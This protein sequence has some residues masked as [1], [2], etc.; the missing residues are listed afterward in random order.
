MELPSRSGTR[1]TQQLLFESFQ[2]GQE[3]GDDIEAATA[4]ICSR[5]TAAGHIRRRDHAGHRSMD[6]A[7][8][9]RRRL[10]RDQRRIAALYH[11]ANRLCPW[12]ERSIHH[13]A[14]VGWGGLLR[15]CRC[16]DL[17]ILAR[18]GLMVGHRSTRSKPDG[19][20]RDGAWQHAKR[21]STPKRWMIE[22][23]SG[24]D[25]KRAALTTLHRHAGQQERNRHDAQ[26]GQYRHQVSDHV[27]SPGVYQQRQHNSPAGTKPAFGMTRAS[28]KLRGAT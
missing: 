13:R 17:G 16:G 20:A 7:A 1:S 11:F 23:V 8:H 19:A 25:T 27:V 18:L 10:A 12:G 2:L 3:P 9:A 15:V 22:A 5:S 24:Q 28:L 26:R 14:A 6:L 4:S 21:P